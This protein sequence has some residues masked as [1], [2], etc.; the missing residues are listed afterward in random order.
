[1]LLRRA[2]LRLR[3]FRELE[4]QAAKVPT[5]NDQ[6]DRNAVELQRHSEW[7]AHYRERCEEL[8]GEIRQLWRERDE[9]TRKIADTGFLRMTGHQVFGSLG[10]V[11]QRTA[12]DTKPVETQQF[13]GNVARRAN[14]RFIKD[15]FAHALPD[16]GG[17]DEAAE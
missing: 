13:A 15:F 8:E 4:A 9:M 16:E 7:H 5:L 10:D 2:L 6:L 11:E 1:M 17:A 14:Q 3:W 12:K